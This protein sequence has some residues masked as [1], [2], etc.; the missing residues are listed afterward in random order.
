MDN[1]IEIQKYRQRLEQ[2]KG[3]LQQVQSDIDSV[4]SALANLQAQAMHI[5]QAQTIIRI[6]GQQMQEKLSWY[7]DDMVTYAMDA[8][9]PDDP[10][11]FKL[12]FIQRRGRTEADLWL[13]DSQGNRIKPQ[14]DDGGGL[15]NVVAFALRVA[16]WGLMKMTRPTIILDEP[17]HYLH[18]RQ[19][20]ARVAELLNVVATRLGIQIIM[21]SGEDES[22][23]II[24]MADRL[25]EI[26]KTG[27]LSRTVW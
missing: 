8:I 22:P 4:E 11:Q 5:E 23:E 25:I 6:V 17:F 1:I 24:S 16:L 26:K 14:D 13:V 12:E 15:V 7:I 10:A 20:Q 9:F 19:A 27:G 2:E 3:K 21:V 18:N